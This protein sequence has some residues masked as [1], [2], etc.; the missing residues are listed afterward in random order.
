MLIGNIKTFGISINWLQNNKNYFLIEDQN[1]SAKLI[2]YVNGQCVSNNIIEGI[3][4]IYSN[5]PAFS[6][7][8][9]IL[10]NW[11]DVFD[12]YSLPIKL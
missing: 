7:A 10:D 11:L 8:N 4:D 2:F 3:E 12:N 6:L 9:W 5:T 1:T